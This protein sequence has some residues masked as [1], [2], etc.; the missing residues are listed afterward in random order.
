MAEMHGISLRGVRKNAQIP[1]NHTHLQAGRAHIHGDNQITI[2]RQLNIPETVFN[3][4]SILWMKTIGKTNE[5]ALSRGA[6][7]QFEI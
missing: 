5:L 7:P 2:E 4:R 3:F 1:A 6:R